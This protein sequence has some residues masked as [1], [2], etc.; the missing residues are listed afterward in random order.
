MKKTVELTEQELNIIRSALQSHK[1]SVGN[2]S[3][4]SVCEE[5][6][7]K[8]FQVQQKPKDPK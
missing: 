4:E 5:L 7:F 3:A 2:A 6:D 1:K 8:L